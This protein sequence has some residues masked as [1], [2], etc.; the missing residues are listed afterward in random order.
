VSAAELGLGV[1]DT[2]L[3]TSP[4][5]VAEFPFA[6]RAAPYVLKNIAY[7]PVNRLDLTPLPRPTAA[8]TAA[9]AAA[10]PITAARPWILQSFV[11]GDEYCTHGTARDGRLL[12]YAC[13]RSS[14]FQLN[15]AHVDRPDIEEWVTRFVRERGLSGQVSFD[16]IVDRAGDVR[17]IE[18]NPRTH[19]AITMFYDQP[20][21]LAA[22]YLGEQ[23]GDAPLVPTKSSR[24]TYW[25]YHEV[26]LMLSHPTSIPDRWRVLRQGKDAVFDLDDPLPFLLTHHL[27]IPSLL[28]RALVR[29]RE[30]TRIDFNIGKLVEPGGD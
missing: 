7:D 3:V 21:A 25:L 2:N 8:D 4:E 14:A 27:Q 1:P 24:P 6:D 13:C 22:A 17:A 19:S 29:G 18:C 12:V 9:F 26:W 20:A 5:Q 16:F 28:L 10:K 11:E 15:Y 23:A 30:W